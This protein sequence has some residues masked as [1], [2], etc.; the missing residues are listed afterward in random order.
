MINKD[1]NREDMNNNNQKVK[2]AN[3]NKVNKDIIILIRVTN[4]Q[5]DQQV[6]DSKI[7][8]MH[9]E[10]IS[11]QLVTTIR[12]HCLRIKEKNYVSNKKNKTRERRN[13]NNK[14]KLMAAHTTDHKHKIK[15]HIQLKTHNHQKDK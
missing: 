10:H 9:M 1:N 11:H 14:K 8:D 6:M 5:V 15:H 4:I 2:I 3:I 13:N 7:W 12:N